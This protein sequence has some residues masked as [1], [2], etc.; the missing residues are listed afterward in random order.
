VSLKQTLT[1]EGL[2]EGTLTPEYK[3]SLITA[4]LAAFPSLEASDVVFGVPAVTNSRRQRRLE[5]NS[6]AIPVAITT[7]SNATNDIASGLG[8][9]SFAGSVMAEMESMG[10]AVVILEQAATGMEVLFSLKAETTSEIEATVVNN[11]NFAADVTAQAKSDSLIAADA[12]VVI[13]TERITIVTLAPTVEPTPLPS[14]GPTTSPTA[15][16]TQI[17]SGRPT[18]TPSLA[19]TAGSCV[20]DIQN[21]DETDVDCGGSCHGCNFG[22]ACLDHTDCQGGAC[23]SNLCSTFSPTLSPTVM[24]SDLPSVSPSTDPSVNPT[25]IPSSLPS[26]VPSG[27]PSEPP[28]AF[29]SAASSETDS[30]LDPTSYPSIYTAPDDDDVANSG[31]GLSQLSFPIAVTAAGLASVALLGSFRYFTKGRASSNATAK[32]KVAVLPIAVLED[33]I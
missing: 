3:A 20:D 15:L 18:H 29:P 6:F 28:T 17:P 31:T 1:I 2:N 26:G 9:P 25:A 4:Y 27:L 19:P 7:S 22:E 5:G 30:N 10:E 24:P 14:A 11:A 12:T 13:D 32:K 33:N 21:N 8:S 23:T 16:P